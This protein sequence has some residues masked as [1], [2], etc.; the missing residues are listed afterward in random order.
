MKPKKKIK[1][2]RI[3]IIITIIVLVV[4]AE[5]AVLLV[6]GGNFFSD[7][8]PFFGGKK[9]LEQYAELVLEICNESKYPAGCYDEEIP[10]LMDFISYEEAFQ[11]TRIIQEKDSNYWYCHVLGHNLSARET[12]KD[13]SL[14][15]DVVARAPSGICSNGA[16]HGAFQEK[17]RVE[18]LSDEELT[19]ILPD[20]RNVCEP[21]EGYSPTGLEQASCYHALG[22]LTMYMTGANIYKS[23]NTCNQITS[24]FKQM[25]Y[26]GSFMQIYQPLEPEDFALILDIAPKS[27][28]ESIEFCNQFSDDDF[29]YGTCIR[30]SWPLWRAEIVTPQGLVAFCD[31]T[32]N[33]TE[34]NKC[35]NA[36][37]YVNAPQLSF[38]KNRMI[39]LCRDLSGDVQ[40]RCFANFASRLIET[41]YRLVD[42]SI[43]LCSVA[44]EF[45]VADR[46][47][48]ELSFYA[49]F[50]YHP[51]SQESQDLCLSLPEKWKNKCLSGEVQSLGF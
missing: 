28:K 17:F 48:Q 34:R 50:N 43:E 51:G 35:L 24:G 25:C 44:E 42:S 41:D 14:W 9:T 18:V 31:R 21:R 46:C 12:A 11:V 15:M 27:Q 32:P 47:Y 23:L 38:N 36:I 39:D 33:S 22:H 49:S 8:K 19:Q 37:F 6:G 13:P 1:F 40:A 45:G 2:E 16:I 26:D 10:N 3:N 5:G 30:E 4:L 29:T 20:L 7:I